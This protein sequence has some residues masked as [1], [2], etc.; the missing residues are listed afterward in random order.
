MEQLIQT[1][2]A[3]ERMDMI[4]VGLNPLNPEHV[5]SF[6]KKGNTKN[7]L[8]ERVK[9]IETLY[10]GRES[11]ELEVDPFALLGREV[12]EINTSENLS[13]SFKES[14]VE[15]GDF[16][17]NL[18]KES[19]EGFVK[20]NRGNT[21]QSNQ[22]YETLGFEEAKKYLNSFMINLQSSSNKNRIEIFKN[23]KSCLEKLQSL[24]GNATNY[25]KY[26]K[27]IE[28]AE[29]NMLQVLNERD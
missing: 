2:T 13:E 27:G 6:R 29:A 20:L 14:M 7:L 28:K 3:K 11:S 19:S 16:K 9:E 21:T 18:P 10:K 1:T 26:L 5:T 22:D 4:S 23:L 8:K 12:S 25:N 24:K 17:P 15:Y